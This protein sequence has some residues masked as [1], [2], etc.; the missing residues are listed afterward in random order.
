MILHSFLISLYDFP[1]FPSWKTL[2]HVYK[3]TTLMFATIKKKMEY[4]AE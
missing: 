4:C 1:K 3:N 2:K